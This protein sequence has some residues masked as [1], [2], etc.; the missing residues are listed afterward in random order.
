MGQSKEGRT[1]VL[2]NKCGLH[3]THILFHIMFTLF[4]HTTSHH[5]THTHTHAYTLQHTCILDNHALHCTH[6]HTHTLPTFTLTAPHTHMHTSPHISHFTSHSPHLTHTTPHTHHTSHTP[7]L[8]HTTPHSHHILHRQEESCLQQ[9]E[10]VLF[11]H[12]VQGQKA[13][14]LR[15]G[16]SK[17]AVVKQSGYSLVF[18]FRNQLQLG[19]LYQDLGVIN[20]N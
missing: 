7:H 4:A 19:V 20:T 10:G 2:S 6:T 5:S 8:T 12:S 14:L 11:C 18:I 17:S 9:V 13:S 16:V 3:T 15:A 1:S